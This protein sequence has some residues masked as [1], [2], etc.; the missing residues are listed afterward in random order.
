MEYVVEHWDGSK[1]IGLKAEGQGRFHHIQGKISYL[2][3][4]SGIQPSPL[5]FLVYV[6]DIHNALT[7]VKPILFA[8]DTNLFLSGQNIDGL[9][10]TDTFN[11]ELRS[12]KEWFTS[13]KLSLNEDKTHSMFF[14][15]PNTH[16]PTTA[17]NMKINDIE[18]E[19]KT[20]TKF[21]G[22]Y[23]DEKLNWS[24]HIEYISKKIC[25]NFG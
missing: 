6:N 24:K 1:V 8:D 13:N 19:Q 10:T 15:L 20:S 23:I 12:L 25:K 4:T 3:G 16:Y 14:T 22:V 5:L 9:D 17:I 18:I 11:K 2:W 21:L 7:L